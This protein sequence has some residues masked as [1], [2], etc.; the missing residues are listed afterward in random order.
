MVNISQTPVAKAKPCHITLGTCK[1]GTVQSWYLCQSCYNSY[2]DSN[3]ESSLQ[4]QRH[5][6]TSV[7]QPP[8]EGT[9]LASSSFGEGQLSVMWSNGLL[10]SYNTALTTGSMLSVHTS[11]R[12]HAFDL[13]SDQMVLDS[14]DQHRQQEPAQQNTGRKKR[15][16][17][18]AAKEPAPDC[19]MVSTAPVPL[20][21]S[22]RG[23]S[24]A[25]I[26]EPSDLPINGHH[27]SELEIAVADTQYGCIQSVTNVKLP[28]SG[29]VDRPGKEQQ[30][31]LQLSSGMGNLVMLLHGAVWYISIQVRLAAVHTHGISLITHWQR[32]PGSVCWHPTRAL[33]AC[34]S[35]PTACCILMF[36]VLPVLG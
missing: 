35:L 7:I 4:G 33:C 10:Q 19:D 26:R 12:L 8:S 9:K 32:L 5:L 15:K 6:S 1:I 11:R 20:L 31:A 16:S 27:S 25:A 18:A 28:G 23:H 36:L 2:S 22:L 30:E 3:D 24:V 21:V 14:Q 13:G 29:A 17:A 34:P